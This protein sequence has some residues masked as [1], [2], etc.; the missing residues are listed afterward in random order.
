MNNLH[1]ELAPVSESAWEQIEEEAART[2]KRYLGG[3]KV[4]DV[5]GPK[6]ADFS[7]IGTGHVQKIV[8]PADGVTA[9][10]RMVLP[11]VELRVPFQL[12]R[13]AIDDAERGSEDSDWDAL[14]EAARKIAFAED[15]VIFDGYAAAGVKGV[16]EVASNRPVTLPVSLSEWPEAVAKAVNALRLAGVNGPYVLVL[17]AD[18][19]TQASGGSEDGYP[20]LQRIKGEVDEVV[21]TPAIEGGVVL[22][23]RG[24]DFEL[25]LG[26]DLSIGYLS[27]DA[28]TVT[29]YF[30]ESMTFRM[31]T[32]EAAVA[33]AARK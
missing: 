5:E 15:S 25:T 30:Q 19:Y 21:W 7:V 29:L 31:L 2:L 28:T 18:A 13:E 6:G 12:S 33:L 8:A 23:K 10:Q 26:Q 3:R 14:K 9:M 4:V 22:T 1:R 27:H 16:R 32:S 24:G 17:G 11:L 20:L